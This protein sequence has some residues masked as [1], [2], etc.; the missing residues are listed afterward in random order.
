MPCPQCIVPHKE[1]SSHK[2]PEFICVAI[3]AVAEATPPVAP[4][5]SVRRIVRK[6]ACPR[7]NLA[8]NSFQIL[9]EAQY[10]ILIIPDPHSVHRNTRG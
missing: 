9:T 10:C 4:P 2:K 1:T 6:R 5:L 7:E 3:Q 8:S